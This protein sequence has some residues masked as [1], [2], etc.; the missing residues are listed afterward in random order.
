M[1]R[2][3]F[4]RESSRPKKIE[5]NE[6]DL[7]PQLVQ[8][9]KPLTEQEKELR[10]LTQEMLAERRREKQELAKNQKIDK[11]QDN[12]KVVE[13]HAVEMENSDKIIEREKIK[14]LKNPIPLHLIVKK[15]LKMRSEYQGH[16]FAE[17]LFLEGVDNLEAELKNE[18]KK[19]KSTIRSDLQQSKANKE[20]K[21]LTEFSD[22]SF[23]NLANRA[24]EKNK[25]IEI[26]E[27]EGQ[28]D[29]LLEGAKS[30][31]KLIELETKKFDKDAEKTF[32]ILMNN[33]ECAAKIKESTHTVQDCS[34]NKIIEVSEKQFKLEELQQWVNQYH[35]GSKIRS[36]TYI[37]RKTKVSVQ[38][39]EGHNFEITPSH[40]KSGNWCKECAVDA[41]KLNPNEKER[42]LEDLRTVVEEKHPGSKILSTEYVNAKKKLEVQ[43]VKGHNFK[44]NPN[45]IKNGYWCKDC[46]VDARKLNP[47]EK[48][49]ALEDL[50]T[51]VEK[52]HPGSKITSTEYVNRKTKLN[53]QCTEGH[54]FKITPSD[55]KGGH[56]CKVCGDKEGGI[57]RRLTPEEQQ[58]ILEELSGTVEKLHPGSRIISTNYVNDNV[59]IEVQCSEGH[60]FKITHSAI[61][62]HWC[63]Q[64]GNKETGFK[65]KL[66]PEEKQVALKD[67]KNDIERSYPG[68]KVIST[69]YINANTKIKVQCSEGHV[70]E[71]TPISIKNDHWCQSCSEGMSE[72]ISRKI[73]EAIFNEKFPKSRPEWL[74]NN[75]GNQMEL[76]GYN[77][78]LGVAFEY[79]G[80]QHSMY[81]DHFHKSIEDF[82]RRQADDKMKIE[83]CEKNGVTLIQ[84]P[85]TIKPDQIQNNITQQCRKQNVNMPQINEKINY[86]ELDIYSSNS[87]RQLGELKEYIETQHPGSLIKSNIYIN[88]ETKIGIQCERGHTFEMVPANVKRGK[89]CPICVGNKRLSI[90]EMKEFVDIQHPGSQVIST[91]Y[92]NS[93][94]KLEIRC[95][96][97]HNFKM[98]SNKIKSGRWCPECSAKESGLKN[99]LTPEKRQKSLERLRDFVETHHHGS[100]II[101][102]EYINALSKVDVQCTKGHHFKMTPA[103]IKSGYWCRRCAAKEKMLNPDDRR[104]AFERLKKI[105]ETQHLGGQLISN[106]YINARTKVSVKCA[107]GHTFEI[108][109]NS[110]KRGH[111]CSI[112]AYKEIAREKKSK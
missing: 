25:K 44:A 49:R 101:S 62:R 23:D 28:I 32:E 70:F 36:T 19:E 14:D 88:S 87:S 109:P 94:T 16:N 7:Y 50:R 56:W 65:N 18:S 54:N 67:L 75:R 98:T 40:I 92:I 72:R 97:G 11:W 57:K 8:E 85:H 31:L 69:E 71:I 108:I 51:V 46:A 104:K 82:K 47:N 95:K 102:S 45:S 96:E 105:I 34:Q 100:R 64:C 66:T 61:N 9:L 26:K 79:Q 33:D 90:N 2:G 30:D 5:L 12:K 89:W 29:E 84:I 15:I 39:A 3:F 68:S 20:S 76:D 110:I 52:I 99:K 93:K 106:E 42:A 4:R 41:R 111:W 107:R 78:K 24:L 48:E 80:A 43:C 91:E 73:F 112:C 37:N 60:I 13:N 59:K 58:R 63:R 17:R 35:P 1:E 74:V 21:K 38:C 10:R 81:S 77:E 83:L 22:A 53:V 55:I 27:L 6:K 103:N 86:R